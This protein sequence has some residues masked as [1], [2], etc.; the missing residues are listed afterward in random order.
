MGY[1]ARQQHELLLVGK[2][3][4]PAKPLPPQRP[5]SVFRGKA[6]GHSGKPKEAIE[7]IEKMMPG[8]KKV[9]LFH[10]GPKRDGW[11]SWGFE[12]GA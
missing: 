1:W 7:L 2:K 6:V 8:A 5:S 10:R 9:E 12:T 4:T 11:V 3:G